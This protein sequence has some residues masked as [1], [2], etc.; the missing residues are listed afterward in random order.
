MSKCNQ[1]ERRI[2]MD[3]QLENWKTRIQSAYDIFC[4]NNYGEKMDPID[5]S[6]PLPIAYTEIDEE[7]FTYEIQVS[8]DF[9]R[10]LEIFQQKNDYVTVETKKEFC[11]ETL[12]QD[13]LHASFEDW[14]SSDN[15]IPYWR[16]KLYT[17]IALVKGEDRL[18][19][20]EF[21]MEI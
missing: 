7:E 14:I 20:D 12:E 18:G 8:I 1:K 19:N 11:F 17:N 3:N 21:E 4:L 5:F 9:Q 16:I 13:L 6:K 2:V 15:G 10:Q